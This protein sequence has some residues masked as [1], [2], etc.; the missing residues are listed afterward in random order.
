MEPDRKRQ[1]I[2][3]ILFTFPGQGAQRPGMLHALPDHPEITRTIEETCG[4]IGSNPLLLDTRQALES[5]YAVQLCLL[6]A[7]VAIARVF[8]AQE[9]GPDIVRG[10]SSGAS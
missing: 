7:G 8:I 2:M 10:R 1:P 3:S 5:T 6:V 4:A 9:A